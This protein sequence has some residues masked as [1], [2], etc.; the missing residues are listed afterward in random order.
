MSQEK[1]EKIGIVTILGGGI[2]LG[3]GN[4]I[5]I[6]YCMS[7]F[8]DGIFGRGSAVPA[9][10]LYIFANVVIIFIITEIFNWSLEE[11]EE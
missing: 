7:Y 2:A 4:L 10:L 1:K 6:L 9:I 11:P 3:I 8:F 5:F